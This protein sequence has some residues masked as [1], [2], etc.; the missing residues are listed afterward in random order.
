MSKQVKLSA[1]TASSELDP[2][3]Q[4]HVQKVYKALATTVLTA[5]V[6]GYYNASSGFGNQLNQGGMIFYLMIANLLWLAFDSDATRRWWALHLFG[7]LQGI[8]LGP[9]LDVTFRI[10]P[11]LPLL[12][13]V[14]TFVV[15]ASFS[16]A[17]MYARRRS[18]LYLGSILGSYTLFMLF[19]Q[20]A[21]WFLGGSLSQYI[22]RIELYIGLGVFCAYVIY[23]TQLIIENAHMAS[24][25][26]KVDES[27]V[28]T[29]A[30]ELFIDFVA[31]FIRIL[32]IL[33][34]NR[35]KDEDDEED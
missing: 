23:D 4:E 33:A 30:L 17:A 5:G 15:F 8:G 18:Y 12:A 26:G 14:L 16:I 22:F 1:V 20:I 11:Q 13:F 19:A 21:N 2:V 35:K 3:V 34:E 29:D 7:M 24:R 31:I 28:I 6:A 25:M 27:Q 32:I 10:D 9:L